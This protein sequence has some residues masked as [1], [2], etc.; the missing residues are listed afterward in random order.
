MSGKQ[1][2][3]RMKKNAKKANN[4]RVK[5]KTLKIKRLQLLTHTTDTDTY[6]TDTIHTAA[7]AANSDLVC[8]ADSRIDIDEIEIE[9]STT[10]QKNK[11]DECRKWEGHRKTMLP[12]Y[13]DRFTAK[14]GLFVMYLTEEGKVIF[15]RKMYILL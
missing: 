4:I 14:K 5:S 7:A 6:T 13:A 15:S 2:Y 11:A 1:N 9:E 10:Y 3:N 12:T 8:N